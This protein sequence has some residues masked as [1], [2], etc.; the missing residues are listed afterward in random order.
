[1]SDDG[2]ELPRTASKGASGHLKL[3]RKGDPSTAL[4]PKHLADLESSGL[5]PETIEA[6]GI[7]SESK[8]AP[9]ADILKWSWRGGG[10]MVIP[11]FDYDSR[12]PT[13][14]RVK[15]DRPRIRKRGGRSK[16]LKYEQP[17]GTGSHPYFGPGTIRE[18]RLSGSRLPIVWVEGE[19]KTLL[20]DQLG[21]AAIGLAGCHNFNDSEKLKKGDGLTWSKTL[22]KYA[23]RFV[24]DRHHIIAYDSDLFAND[25]VMLAARRLAGLLLD[26]GGAS[27]KFLRVPV[28]PR[29]EDRGVGVDDYYVEHGEHG[30]SKLREVFA[31]AELVA[32]GED[33]TPLAPRDPLL[34]LSSVSWLRSAKLDPDLRLPP[35]FDIRRDR[36]LWVE[37]PADKPDGDQREIMRSVVI[38]VRLLDELD[39][40]E[41][42]IEI[43]YHARGQWHRDTIDRKAL[44]DS[45]RALAELPP[46]VAIDSNNAAHV[47]LWLG[48]YMR[49]NEHR[50]RAF[51]F[52]SACGW[53]DT[54]DERC[55]LLDESITSGDDASKIVPDDSGGRADILKALK[56][57]GEP[58]AHTEA[59]RDAFKEDPV[60]AIAILGALAAPLLEPLGAPNFAINFHGDSSRGKSSMLKIASSVYGNPRGEQWVGSWNA[61][62]VGMELR[63]AMLSHLPLCFDEV[64]A[65]DV[66]TIDR[67]I[68]MLIN[69]TGKARGDVK[70]TLRKNFSWRTI[71]LSTGEHELVDEQANTGAQVRVLQ[72]RVRGFG[73]LDA[74][75]VDSLR[76][77]CERNHGHV[78]RRWIE[79]LVAIEDWAE[80]RELFEKA[81]Q[82]F[83]AKET[84]ALMQR[85]SVYYALLAV[86][87]HLAHGTLGIGE[88]GGKTVRAMF[89]DTTRRREVQGASERAREVVSE[90]IASEP[91]TFPVLEKHSG[92][93]LFART[94]ASV[95]RINGVRYCGFV[96]FL[97]SEL[98]TR[99]Q[100]HGISPAEVTSAWDDAGELDTDAGRKTKRMRWDG[101]RVNVI[102]V[103]CKSLGLDDAT[104]I[105][106]E[107]G[108]DFDD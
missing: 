101:K 60:C 82:Q 68:Y 104:S 31:A 105:Q 52:A 85:Q 38:P 39:G 8:S 97:P 22:R 80:Y 64:G 59:V 2:A 23:E 4:A 57:R 45:R 107:L 74:H 3:T 65:G 56:P 69:G 72:F 100:A 92:G 103:S 89:A 10:G 26:G 42:R 19:K 50:M 86:A 102:A 27:V 37:P 34:K 78:G 14:A 62:P 30:E 81:K 87:E 63:A 25:N 44:R 48:E 75:G 1:M 70:V 40:D 88:L 91:L 93:A 41:Q 5:T 84:G 24:R 77:A 55:F 53:Q 51:H 12:K 79:A 76:D 66:K 99:L 18:Q 33:I 6:S 96:C 98:R 49:H 9:I 94:A 58:G 106:T 83:R 36:S 32:E 54:E 47:V 71:V 29:D 21:F 90:W 108:G 20:L 7:H 61:S 11:F 17:I 28:D 95:K 15:P 46:G 73:G 67:W 16:P 43:T 35:R 13:M